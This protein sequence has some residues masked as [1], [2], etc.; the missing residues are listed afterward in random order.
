MEQVK[1]LITNQ[2]T[3]FRHHYV[4]VSLCCPSRVSTLRGQFVD[5]HPGS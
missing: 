4:N 2:G 1:A 5:L 3:G